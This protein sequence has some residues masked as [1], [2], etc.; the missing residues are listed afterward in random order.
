MDSGV[1]LG[2]AH[3]KALNHF[4]DNTQLLKLPDECKACDFVNSC[5]GGCHMRRGVNDYRDYWCR[6]LC[7]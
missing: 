4:L 5:K 6:K 2:D 7:A 1:P 3:M